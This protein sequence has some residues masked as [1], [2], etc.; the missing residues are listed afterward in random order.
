MKRSALTLVEIVVA[1]VIIAT[2]FLGLVATFSSVRRYTSRANI[3]LTT[4]NFTRQVLNDLYATVRADQWNT[5]ATGGAVNTPI[6]HRNYT[7]TY[8]APAPV[9]LGGG[10]NSDYRQVSVTVTQPEIR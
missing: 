4:V 6:D 9:A 10:N 5:F 1:L 2:V 7:A 3:R 8:S